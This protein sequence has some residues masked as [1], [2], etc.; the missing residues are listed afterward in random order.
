MTTK[1]TVSMQDFKALTKQAGLRLTQKELEQL[2]PLYEKALDI[3]APLHAIDFGET[4]TASFYNPAQM[5]KV[6]L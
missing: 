5:P 6:Q 3:M 4:E 1:H 2:K